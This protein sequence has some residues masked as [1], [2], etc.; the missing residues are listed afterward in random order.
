MNTNKVRKIE[1]HYGNTCKQGWRKSAVLNH[2]ITSANEGG[3]DHHK[4]VA[5]ECH[6]N[7]MLKQSYYREG[8]ARAYP[9]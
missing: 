4:W 5:A 3:Q 1:L 2:V 8:S 9:C 6:K 7:D